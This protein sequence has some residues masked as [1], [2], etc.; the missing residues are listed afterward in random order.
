MSEK[1]NWVSVKQPSV[2]IKGNAGCGK[3][4]AASLSE[5]CQL[6]P[7][8]DPGEIIQLYLSTRVRRPTFFLQDLNLE[9]RGSSS[10]IC[11]DHDQGARL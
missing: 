2:S 8:S 11:H 1:K 10:V 5:V 6:K 3:L 4:M 9:S 7:R